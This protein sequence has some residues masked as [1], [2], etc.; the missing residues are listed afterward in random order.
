MVSGLGCF[1]EGLHREI[2]VGIGV[3]GL[4]YGL[5]FSKS[6]KPIAP[7]HGQPN[8]RYRDLEN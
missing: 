5:G 3:Q 6:Q 2:G 8:T 4:L 7:N 1:V